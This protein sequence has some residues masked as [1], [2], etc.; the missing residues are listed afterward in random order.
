M[1]KE[2]KIHKQMPLFSS[3]KVYSEEEKQKDYTISKAYF[4]R[5]KKGS[6]SKTR[7]FNNDCMKMA[8]NYGRSVKNLCNAMKNYLLCAF[9]LEVPFLISSFPFSFYSTW[10]PPQNTEIM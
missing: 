8:C 4:K 1:N 6:E 3:S 2:Y 10:S 5:S 9:W 7:L